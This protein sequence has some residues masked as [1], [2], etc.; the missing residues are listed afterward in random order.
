MLDID[1]EGKFKLIDNLKIQKWEWGGLLTPF[2][3]NK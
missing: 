2:K 1:N 3:I